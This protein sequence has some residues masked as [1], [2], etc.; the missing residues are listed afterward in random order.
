MLLRQNSIHSVSPFPTSVRMEGLG[1]KEED[2][3]AG[4]REERDSGADLEAGAALP[5][6]IGH[7]TV[8]RP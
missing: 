1:E 8:E 7:V 4:G 6:L 5:A 2:V 3:S